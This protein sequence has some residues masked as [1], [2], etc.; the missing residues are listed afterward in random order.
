MGYKFHTHYRRLSFNQKV[1]TGIDLLTFHRND[2][3]LFNLLTKWKKWVLDVNHILSM[4]VSHSS[5]ETGV[6]AFPIETCKKTSVECSHWKIF[7]DIDKPFRLRYNWLKIC[8]LL[9][10]DTYT[11]RFSLDICFVFWVDQSNQHTGWVSHRCSKTYNR[12]LTQLINVRREYQ[13]SEALSVCLNGRRIILW[14]LIPDGYTTE[15]DFYHEK[16]NCIARNAKENE[17]ELTSYKTARP[18]VTKSNRKTLY[19]SSIGYHTPNDLIP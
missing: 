16:F 13:Y 5:D 6:I 7:S 11:D 12:W 2:Q 4:A 9:Q 3:W 18:H 1:D 8:H 17:I 19:C 14:E 10:S 15:A